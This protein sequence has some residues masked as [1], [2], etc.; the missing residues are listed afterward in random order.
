MHWNYDE[1]KGMDFGM[2]HIKVRASVGVVNMPESF[3]DLA[4]YLEAKTFFQGFF[5]RTG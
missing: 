3:A 4:I 5:S 2:M 1:E